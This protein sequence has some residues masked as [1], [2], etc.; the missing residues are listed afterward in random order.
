MAKFF[1]ILEKIVGYKL[2]VAFGV[3]VIL[4][5]LGVI[6]EETK[7]MVIGYIP[8]FYIGAAIVILYKIVIL[9]FTGIYQIKIEKRKDYL[10]EILALQK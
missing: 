5:F 2:F 3:F 7:T 10:D 4:S 6:D 1:S 8:Y 9:V